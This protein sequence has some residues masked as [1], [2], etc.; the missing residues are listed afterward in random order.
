[1]LEN[2]DV[3]NCCEYELPKNAA[4]KVILI[5]MLVHIM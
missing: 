2:G 3:S 1:M 5:Q 4:K